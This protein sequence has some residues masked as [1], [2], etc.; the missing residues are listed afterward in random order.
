MPDS[1][2]VGFVGIGA[3]KCGS[4]WLFYALGQHPN[5]CLSEPK[6]INYFNKNDSG[7]DHING[8][9]VFPSNNPNYANDFDWYASHYKHCSVNSLKG[10]FSPQYI[11]DEEAP[12]RIHQNF[13]KVKLLVCLRNPV[14]RAYSEYNLHLRTN[15]TIQSFETY[16]E[17]ELAEINDKSK[18]I[19]IEK[20]KNKDNEKK[21][22]EKGFYFEQ[23]KPWFEL[24]PKEKILI[25]STE[26]FGENAND[27]FNS[28]FE[29]L[30][31]KSYSIKNSKRMQKGSYS[32]LNSVTREKLLDFYKPKNIQ[33]YNLVGKDFGW[34]K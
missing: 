5:I 7:W 10:E 2:N 4:T 14:D 26:K 3:P 9:D 11:Y 21:Y 24:F 12:S 6:E 30:D 18:N 20:G 15:S 13:P 28:I 29:F 27:V 17:K 33:L 16:V 34:N 8:T 19:E 32:K 23:L 31:L 1:L 25:L 22:L